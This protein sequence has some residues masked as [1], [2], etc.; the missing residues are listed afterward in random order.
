VL[1]RGN[2]RADGWAFTETWVVVIAL[3]GDEV[4]ADAWIEAH[5]DNLL[6]ALEPVMFVESFSPAVT[7][8]VGNSEALALMITGRS[9]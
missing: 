7:P 3:A 9:E 2:Q 8:L 4:Q 5:I 1:W 6:E